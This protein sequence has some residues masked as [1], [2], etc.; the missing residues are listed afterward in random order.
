MK[1][2]FRSCPFSKI[3]NSN[4]PL[5]TDSITIPSPRCLGKLCAQWWW[6]RAYIHWFAS[7]MNRHLFSFSKIFKV[8][9]E[10]MSHLLDCI[11]SPQECSRLSILWKQHIFWFDGCSCSYTWCLLSWLSHIKTYSTL[12]LCRIK[13]LICFIYNYHIF[14]H[15]Y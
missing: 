15:F 9:C 1:V 3:C 6:N 7:I 2:S 11:T 5:P 12:T 4:S 14:K 10:L 8:S 13:Y